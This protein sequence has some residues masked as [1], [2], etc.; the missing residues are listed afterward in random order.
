LTDGGQNGDWILHVVFLAVLGKNG[1]SKIGNER[2]TMQPSGRQIA[3]FYLTM[4]CAIGAGIGVKLIQPYA[5]KVS[6][7]FAESVAEKTSSVSLQNGAAVAA[8]IGVSLLPAI[9]AVT[10]L[11][12]FNFACYA[13]DWLR[14]AARGTH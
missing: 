11:V 14:I 2:L 3:S 10:I 8:K 12:G 4:I 6:V 13:R 5:Q 9:G 7:T 1:H